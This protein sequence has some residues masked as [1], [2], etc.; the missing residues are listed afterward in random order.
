MLLM[1]EYVMNLNEKLAQHWCSYFKIA[2]KY[3]S[4]LMTDML[5]MF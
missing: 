5:N 3:G 2:R 4:Y 1:E